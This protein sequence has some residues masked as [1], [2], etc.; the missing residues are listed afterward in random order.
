M[1]VGQD[2]E[3]KD[4]KKK[5]DDRVL[6]QGSVSAQPT[7]KESAVITTPGHRLTGDRYPN[8]PMQHLTIIDY[9]DSYSIQPL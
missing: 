4:S 6:I 9:T 1:I 8:I 5:E 7:I 3:R 2:E